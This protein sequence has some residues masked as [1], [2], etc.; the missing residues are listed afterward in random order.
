MAWAEILPTDD[1]RF[2]ETVGNEPDVV[3]LLRFAKK[4]FHCISHHY[5]VP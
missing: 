3:E 1:K 5:V 2:Y 4:R